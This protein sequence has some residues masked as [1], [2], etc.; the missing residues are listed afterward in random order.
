M[1]TGL[2]VWSIIAALVF[3]GLW[4]G[5]LSI[6]HIDGIASPIDRVETV[7][8][9]ARISLVG[10]R[11]APQAITIVAIDDA[12]VL[13]AGGYPLPR[14]QLADLIARID[15][16]GAKALAID[17]LLLGPTEAQADTALATSLRG[18]PTVI[19]GAAR[20]P[21]SPSH[22]AHVPVP[23]QILRPLPLLEGA[24]SLGLVNVVA[25]AGG[26]PRQVPM[27][28]K[29]AGSPEASIVLRAVEFYLGQTPVMATNGMTIGQRA[30]PL[31]LGWHLALNYYGPAGTIKTVSALD[32]LRHGDP[33]LAL[34]GR[35]V[36]LGATATGVGDRF[37]TPFD[38]ILPGAEVLATG[39]SNLLDGS[40]LQ[41]DVTVRRIDGLA[42]MLITITAV[43]AIALLPLAAGSVAY[44]GILLGWFAVIT[45]A[46]G[47][48]YWLSGALPLAASLP[49][50]A[51][52]ALARQVHD[53]YRMR[54]LTSAQAALAQ[55]QST[56]IAR[57]IAEDTS[58]LLEPREQNAAILFVDLAGF[59]GISERLGPRQTRDML[60]TFHTIVTEECE[61]R[62]GLV[63]DFMGDGVMVG[64]GIPDASEQ[65]A[66]NAVLAAFQLIPK[67]DDW[68]L[69]A[70]LAETGS[71][72]V[73]VHSGPVVLS[74]LGHDK[75]QQI[76]ATGDCVNVA[77]RLLEAA[78]SRGAVLALSA[79]VVQAA[80]LQ[81]GLMADG[82]GFE[83]I[84]I[85][86]REQ[87]IDVAVWTAAEIARRD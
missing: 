78:R 30:V 82:R 35:L 23:G 63:M 2:P 74:R 60:K 16:A 75:H 52:V 17:M 80:G 71:M 48:F 19:A 50:V 66:A 9:D 12:T 5:L 26:T 38:P 14:Q 79:D 61:R 40:A 54:K 69:G 55:F 25:D 59:T 27:L 10:G 11:P 57:R 13:D 20:F 42:A 58:F 45:L 22:D 24:A 64:F 53:R 47:Q 62:Q 6:R 29:A 8:V 41:R 70:R 3:G 7:L 77:S 43:A 36:V 51:A 33:D 84:A 68:L 1:R 72:R 28:F 67:V 85:R 34:K 44:V 87:A 46:F 73:G 76:A 37:T 49:P 56:T 4:A 21:D 15:R 83:R 18:L 81:Q 32:L 39:M 65:D 86:G 31:D